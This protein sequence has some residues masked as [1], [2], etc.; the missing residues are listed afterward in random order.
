MR[1]KIFFNSLVALLL[2]LMTSTAAA[3]GLPPRISAVIP[4]YNPDGIDRLFIVGERLPGGPNLKVKL[5]DHQVTVRRSEPTLIV[6]K[7][8]HAFPDG[9]YHLKAFNNWKIATFTASIVRD[10]EG[11]QGPPGP[12]GPPGP[13]GEQGTQGAQG[14]TGPQG[15]PGEAGPPGA[16]GIDG[17]PGADG[18]PGPKGD[19]GDTGPAGPPGEQGIQGEPGFPGTPGA[20][21]Q[22]GEDGSSCTVVDGDGFATINCEDGTTATVN[23]GA[24]GQPGPAGMSAQAWSRSLSGGSNAI[25]FQAGQVH[26]WTKIQPFRIDFELDQPA[27]VHF[28]ATGMQRTWGGTGTSS[29]VGYRFKV[30]SSGKG[31]ASWGQRIVMGSP[32]TAWFVPWSFSHEQSM[33][34]GHHWVE[35]EVTANTASAHAAICGETNGFTYGYT[36]CQLHVMAFYDD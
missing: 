15:V 10:G 29:F 22:D 24:E 34:E 13:Q 5:G 3:T 30:D 6:V 33:P 4:D 11:T 12:E 7:L 2:L 35:V 31:D 26:P 32:D 19:K 36:S 27:H 1:V 23:D 8:P 20:P 18:A 28:F 25:V 17:A 9:S 21:G 14:E 16:D